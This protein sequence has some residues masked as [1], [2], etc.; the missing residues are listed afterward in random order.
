[1]TTKMQLGWKVFLILTVLPCCRSLEVSIPER[2]YEVVRGGDI[3][4]TCS[5]IPARP[6]ANALVITWEAYPAKVG[7]PMDAVATYFINNPV[8]IAP[9]YEGRA[10]MEVSLDNQVSTLTLTKVTMQDSRS[11]QCSVMIPNDD[12]GTTAATTSLLVLVPPSPP[13][14][15]VQ[16][17]AAYFHNI[18]L[19]CSSQE[20]SPQPE[21]V[22]SSYN[23]ENLPRD[24]PPRANQNHGI[25]SL[26]NI[27]KDTSGFYICTSTN[28]IG[29]ARCNYTLVVTPGSMNI[30]STAGIIAGVLAGVV[31]LAI[32]IFCCCKKKGK[33]E[34]Y[35]EGS[36]E[37]TAYY[38]RDAPEAGEPYLDDKSKGETKQVNQHEV[39]GLPPNNYSEEPAAHKFEDDHH[40]YNS[41]KER[42]DG[43]G[44]DVDSQRYQNDQHDRRRGSRDR[45]DD[46]RD[47]YGGSRDRLDDQ[48]DRYGGSR[49]RL[50][51]QRD[52]YGGSRDRLDDQHDRY[53]GSRDRLHD[54]RDRYGGSRDRLDDQH[55]RYR[56]S[57][58]RLDDQRER[59]GGSRDRL[60]DQR[61]R[62]GGS[63]DRLDDQ[64]DRNR[65]SRD[66]LD[67]N[68][69]QSRNRY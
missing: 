47:R 32:L 10:T 46:Q 5:F 56:G 11:Y 36:P 34:K 57:R 62:Y 18:T 23:V 55:D 17:E 14:C 51:D 52:R 4:L 20:G 65:G 54:Q 49:D 44:S 67:Y 33:K 30:G 69:D 3:T 7:E 42:Y 8:D 63:R 50:D 43:K 19:T 21:Y 25:L 24:L 6:V 29:S 31:L 64:C 22:W 15:R 61:D 13:I 38:D 27:S 48:R 66:R 37:E 26:F 35:A 39:K 68:D 53:G 41:S 60:D 16:G 59:Y 58:D 45:L 1:M 12:E 28:R 2:A 9:N 40:S